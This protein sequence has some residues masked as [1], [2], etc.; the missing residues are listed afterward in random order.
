MWA[1]E[2]DNLYSEMLEQLEKINGSMHDSVGKLSVSLSLIR[3]TMISL[4]EFI[5]VNSFIDEEQEIKFFKYV[6]PRFAAWQT[7]YIELHNIISSTP[8]GTDQ[9]IK[10]YY[11][12]E[13]AITDRF[14]K[15]N[16]FY[17]QYYL[18]DEHS[19]DRIYFLRR[20]RTQFPPGSEI[21]VIESDFS[22]E[23]DYLFSKFRAYEMLRDYIIKRVKFLHQE[24]DRS[25]INE[26][27]DKMKRSWSGDKI[28][29][30]EIA[31]GIYYTQRLNNGKAEISDII[32]WLE[33]SLNTDLSQA[34]RMFVD[35]RRRKTISYTKFIDEMR[36]EINVHIADSIKYRPKF[37]SQNK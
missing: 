29:L 34:Y 17:F 4:R 7:Y 26:L 36:H 12:N 2:I 1:K 5:K 22:T 28:E 14:F 11:I 37:N 20:N 25:R 33:E 19:K 23:L 8:I 9:M 3:Q 15:I 31:Y 6:K 18:K 13:I 32:D 16:A 24:S 10:D 21:I 27:S 35:I 30:V